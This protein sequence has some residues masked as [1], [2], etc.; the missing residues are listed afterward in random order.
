MNEWVWSNGG[1]ILTG[2]NW[3]TGRKT[4]YSFGGSSMNEYGAMVEWYWRG[5]TEVLRE[6]LYTAWVVDECISM[7]QWWNDTDRGK[8]KYLRNKHLLFFHL[9]PHVDRPGIEQVSPRWEASTN[10]LS[11][12]THSVAT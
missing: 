7:E 11:H 9:K 10:L 8:P 2:V 3:S 1:M 12:G 5:K 4:L 6:K